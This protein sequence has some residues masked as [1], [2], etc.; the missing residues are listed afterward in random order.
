MT[1]SRSGALLRRNTPVAVILL[2][3]ALVPIIAY[4]ATAGVMVHLPPI[5]HLIAVTGA[6]ALAGAA[7]IVLSVIAVRLN[8]GRAV[9]LGFAFSIM[10]VMLV[11]H[12]LATPGV[13][14]GD[15]G[16]VQAAGALNIP[17]GGS[18][19]AATAL[20]GL[21]RP[22]SA[23]RVLRVQLVALVALTVLG[24]IALV[25]P[26]LVPDA[27]EYGSTPAHLLIV[28]GGL[29]LAVLAVRASRTFLLTRRTAD[30]LVA[31][32]VVFLA[33]AEYGLLTYDMM[34]LAWW[35]AH[36][37]EVA[38][39][40]LVGIPAA[41]DLRHSTASLPLAGGLRAADLVADEETFLGGRVHALMLRL[42]EKDGSTEGH[43]R[44]VALLAVR[45]GEKLGLPADRL[46]LLALGG[47]L[48]DMGKLAVPDAILNKPGTLTDEE[49]NVI[50]GHPVW[51]REL[52]NEIGG[53]PPLVLE[54]VESHHE[55]LDGRGYPNRADAGRLDVEV[56]ILTVADVYDALTADRVYREAWPAE[57]ALGLL[58]E[59]T[60]SAFD[61]ACVAALRDVVA[62][63]VD[64]P[65]WRASL[66]AAAAAAPRPGAPRAV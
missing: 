22:R 55:R 58:D 25:L 9:M 3:A 2:T 7:A 51:G 46:R 42:A 62:P 8:D 11:F 21:R 5:V 31:V 50:R 13:L 65:G 43:T 14:L 41:L 23:G 37:V 36:A 19:L 27:P 1:S 54:L 56:R 47:L 35:A 6:G 59:D 39:I 63:G 10:A 26:R 34:D 4:V 48:H 38:G 16:L 28:A 29:T 49:F 60:G 52:L 30:L 40:G 18:I 66:G 64:A 53:F 20:P 17:I 15:N 45:V 57:R 12:A 33:G 61:A 44:R 24:A 32:G